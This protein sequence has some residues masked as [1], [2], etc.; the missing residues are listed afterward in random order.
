M[1]GEL[2]KTENGWQIQTQIETM[3]VHRSCFQELTET[4]NGI[5]TEYVVIKD[6]TND[7]QGIRYALPIIEKSK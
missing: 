3:P 4:M 1:Q 5:Q 2:I 7:N 6:F